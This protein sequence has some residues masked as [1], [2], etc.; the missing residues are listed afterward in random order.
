MDFLFE[1]DAYA[2]GA[3]CGIS[4]TPFDNYTHGHKPAVERPARSIVL[5]GKHASNEN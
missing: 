3:D 1:I 4:F 5:C 2:T